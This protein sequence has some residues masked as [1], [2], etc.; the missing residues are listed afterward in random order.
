MSG[1]H[2]DQW[3]DDDEQLARTLDDFEQGNCTDPATAEELEAMKRFES[4]LADVLAQAPAP[5][6]SAQAFL[7]SLTDDDAVPPPIPFPG[8][9]SLE[10]D[11][12][13]AGKPE[14]VDE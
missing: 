10:D 5:K 3:S 7:A 13:A 11:V 12:Q 9:G 4:G 2:D 8:S 14:D 6:I 1:E